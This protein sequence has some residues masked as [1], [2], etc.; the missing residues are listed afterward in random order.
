MHFLH[1]KVCPSCLP[2]KTGGKTHE[3]K[4]WTA[5]I[6]STLLV[7]ML[8]SVSVVPAASAY[9]NP[10]ESWTEVNS[11]SYGQI[12]AYIA[13]SVGYFGGPYIPERGVYECN[14]RM[15]GVGDTRYNDGESASACRIQSLEIA[16]TYN[17]PHQSIWT[18]TDPVRM[19]A[20]PRDNGNSA[21]Y[22]T[23]AYKVS[24]LAISAVSPYAGFA[25]SAADL[26]AFM[27]NGCDDSENGE[28]VWRKWEH[29]PDQ[30]DVGHFFWW[31][32]DIDP[33][34]TI[35]FT[36]TDYLFG[37]VYEAVG[38]GWT[39]TITTPSRSPDSM[40]TVEREKYGIEIIPIDELKERSG[41][42]NIASETVDEL[43]RYGEPV[44]Y[45]HRLPVKAIPL[46]PD[47]EEAIPWI[48]ERTGYSRDELFGVTNPLAATM[49]A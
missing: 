30:T 24:S 17:K 23:V 26:V 14:F 8:V 38:V 27:L 15:A 5:G 36:V 32:I 44:Y 49:E 35:E 34:Q 40:T 18:S 4:N 20:W 3:R 43:I 11:A 48:L 37:P 33:G 41:E 22:Y 46:N 29:N 47:K 45:A 2:G 6:Q 10:D 9:D 7:A 1:L 21:Y 19:G 28:I 25:L 31:L 39:F 42:L 13:S 12:D 16:E